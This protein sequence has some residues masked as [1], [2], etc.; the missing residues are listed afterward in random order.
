MTPQETPGAIWR[1]GQRGGAS[2]GTG[3]AV[4]GCLCSGRVAAL[5]RLGTLPRWRA[6]QRVGVTA[7]CH[8]Q[9]WGVRGAPSP[10]RRSQ[11]SS[12]PCGAVSSPNHPQRLAGIPGNGT[13]AA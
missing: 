10:A 2:E 6:P 11:N 8:R 7:G 1:R 3:C 9:H 13:N 5:P 12:E 4:T